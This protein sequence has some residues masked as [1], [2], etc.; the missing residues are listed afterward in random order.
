M[1]K[2]Y[3]KSLVSLKTSIFLFGCSNLISIFDVTMK[4]LKLNN[5]W[6]FNL[7]LRS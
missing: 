7:R 2:N 1:T 5:W 3:A 6:W 4:T